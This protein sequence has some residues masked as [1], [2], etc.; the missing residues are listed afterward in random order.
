M[1]F[2][3]RK[4]EKIEDAPGL[5]VAAAEP[6]GWAAVGH[7]AV[8]DFIKAVNGKPVGDVDALETLMKDIASTQQARVVFFVRRGIH[9]LFVEIEPAWKPGESSPSETET[10]S[11]KDPS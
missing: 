9:T 8:G 2:A 10:S 11:S 6:G 7:L 3:D 5:V 4:K 1:G